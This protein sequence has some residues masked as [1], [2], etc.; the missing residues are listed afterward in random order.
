[1]IFIEEPSIPARF[2]GVNSDLPLRSPVEAAPL[3][4]QAPEKSSSRKRQ[5]PFTAEDAEKRK[6]RKRQRLFTV[7]LDRGDILF[8]SRIIDI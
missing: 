4:G 1:M 7:G 3:T 6:S 8:R 2:P 5:R